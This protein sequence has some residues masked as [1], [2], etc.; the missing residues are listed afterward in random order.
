M[1]HE[2][3]SILS[4]TKE[5]SLDPR[6]RLD[7]HKAGDGYAKLSQCVQVSRSGVKRIISRF[8]ESHTI[9]IKPDR[10]RVEDFKESGKKTG[11][12]RV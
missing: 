10:G 8:K 3:K 1:S 11:E 5:V 2:K 7:A 4:N 6:Q 12:R 9:Q